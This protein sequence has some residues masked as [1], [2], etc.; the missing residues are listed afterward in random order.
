MNIKTLQQYPNVQINVNGTISFL[1]VLRFDELINWFDENKKLFNQINWSNIR[2]PAK[3]CANV[4]PD[5]LKKK[6]IDKYKNLPL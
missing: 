4:L 6:L 2:G 1:S 3:L 5:D